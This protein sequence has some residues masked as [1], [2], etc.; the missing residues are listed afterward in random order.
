MFDR[1]KLITVRTFWRNCV[2]NKIRM[3]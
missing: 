3:C 1:E 2:F